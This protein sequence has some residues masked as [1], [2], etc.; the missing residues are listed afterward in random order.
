[1]I[2]IKSEHRTMFGKKITVNKPSVQVKKQ[3]VKEVSVTATYIYD[4]YVEAGAMRNYKLD[5]S[6]VAE[7]LGLSEQI[8]KRNRLKLIKHNYFY[9]ISKKSKGLEFCVYF[10]GRK[11]VLEAK[12]YEKL[13][14]FESAYNVRKNVSFKNIINIL[15]NEVKETELRNQILDSLKPS[16]ADKYG[17]AWLHDYERY[18]KEK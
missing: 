1:M 13:F 6:K 18:V 14:G 7:R 15:D 17:N 4:F 11:A 12:Y 16:S 3:M 5:D 8:V 10:L 9:D 2:I